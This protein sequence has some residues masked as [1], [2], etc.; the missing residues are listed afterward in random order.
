VNVKEKSVAPD[1]PTRNVIIASMAL[2]LRAAARWAWQ[3]PFKLKNRNGG[4]N[5][6]IKD[7]TAIF[8]SYLLC[9][10]GWVCKSEA[11]RVQWHFFFFISTA[12]S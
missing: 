2:Q 11:C 8:D 9:D 1:A 10:V 3:F 6:Q 4:A 5:V 7:D 12:R